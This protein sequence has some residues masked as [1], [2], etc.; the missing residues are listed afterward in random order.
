MR[1]KLSEKER[2]ILNTAKECFVLNGIGNTTMQDIAECCQLTRQT[3][4][5]HFKSVDNLMLEVQLNILTDLEKYFEKEFDEE[6]IKQDF[7]TTKHFLTLFFD[8]Y[9]QH[10]TDIRYICLFDSY[11][12]RSPKSELKEGYERGFEFIKDFPS[13][14]KIAQK[15]GYVRNDLSPETIEWVI[16]NTTAGIALR[17]SLIGY[18]FHLGANIS[19]TELLNN[20]LEMFLCFLKPQ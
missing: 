16:L 10:S 9:E 4:Y 2:I 5:K 7:D 14:I 15:K 20:I 1:D 13:R 8:Y 3:L 18:N 19:K 11:Y 12:R 6:C 17:L